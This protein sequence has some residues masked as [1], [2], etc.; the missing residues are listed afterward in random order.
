[1][2]STFKLLFYINRNKVKTDGTTAVMCRISIDGKTSVI[3]TSI[4]CRPE[5]WNAAKSEVKTVRDNN[6]LSEFRERL[7]QAY[8]CILKEQ[9]AVS[10]E[11]LKNTIVGV[12]TIPTMLLQAGEAEIERLRVRSMEINS[13]STYRESKNTQVNLQNFIRSRGMEDIALA[14]ITEEFGESFKLFLKSTQERKSSYINRC[15]TW[16]NRLIY[17]AIDQEVLRSNPIEDVRLVLV[18]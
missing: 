6:L 1:M 3:T 17:I 4:Y 11:L 16:L 15:I 8:D 7:E 9:G 5:D 14:D 18:R 12:N 10:S 2:R 13:N